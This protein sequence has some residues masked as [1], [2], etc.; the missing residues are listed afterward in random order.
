MTICVAAVIVLTILNHGRLE[1]ALLDVKGGREGGDVKGETEE[2]R[3]Y[4]V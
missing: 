1:Q 3:L 4:I 2:L